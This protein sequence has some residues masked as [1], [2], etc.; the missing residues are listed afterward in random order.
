LR[1]SNGYSQLGI[2][3]GGYLLPNWLGQPI[4]MEQ[5]PRVLVVDDSEIVR[6]LVCTFISQA[7]LLVCGEADNGV[8]AIEQAKETKPDLIVLD[9]SMPTMNGDQA[10]AILKQIMPEV[11]IVLFTM[12]GEAASQS[13]SSAAGIDLVLSKPD[14]IKNVVDHLRTLFALSHPGGEGRD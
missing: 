9:L 6:R 8:T 5:I 3:L 12:H 2:E 1:F 4:V 13:I 10:A 7:G 11:P 14:G